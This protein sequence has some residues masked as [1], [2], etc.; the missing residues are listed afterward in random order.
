MRHFHLKLWIIVLLGLSTLTTDAQYCAI[1]LNTTLLQDQAIV[2]YQVTDTHVV[3]LMSESHVFS[4]LYSV[5]I[6]GGEVIQLNAPHI[7]PDFD[8]HI[9][10]EYVIYFGR[11]GQYGRKE[12]YRVPITGGESVQ[13]SGL[14][15]TEL[16]GDTRDQNGDIYQYYI[17][18]DRII[19]QRSRLHWV[20]KDDNYDANIHGTLYSVYFDGGEIIHLGK[21]I[22]YH[23]TIISFSV[24]DSHIIY[25]ADQNTNDVFEIY[26][27]TMEGD[28]IT[29]LNAPLSSGEAISGG[30]QITSGFVLYVLE[31]VQDGDDAIMRVPIT[32]GDVVQLSAPVNHPERDIFNRN[33]IGMISQDDVVVYDH[34]HFDGIYAVSIHGGDV[35]RLDDEILDNVS[36]RHYLLIDNRVY[37]RVDAPYSISQ[38]W[39]VS[40][41]GQTLPQK[42]SETG[43]YPGIGHFWVDGESV[44][45]IENERQIDEFFIQLYSVSTKDFAEPIQLTSNIDTTLNGLFRLRATTQV[46]NGVLY[47]RATED[48]NS[49]TNLYR[50]AVTGGEIIQ[51]NAPMPP[52]RT[53]NTYQITDSYVVYLTDQDTEGLFELY[54]ISPTGCD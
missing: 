12:F 11:E 49:T 43:I 27:M 15:M 34:S 13:L 53:V 10:D 35:I 46:H 8:Y 19:Y 47:F 44:V 3:Y 20:A 36:L 9:V 40:V 16:I 6:Q 51:L 29:K 32:G 31:T 50:I 26:S 18:D 21:S 23:T 33:Y 4:A 22:P 38:L 5:P 39:A 28:N 37:F 14:H 30:F 54:S 45:Y 24:T 2:T 48:D 17:L 42:L 25:F 1:K 7:R 41:D 52:N